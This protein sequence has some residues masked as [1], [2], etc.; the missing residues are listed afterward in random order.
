MIAITVGPANHVVI[1]CSVAQSMK[2]VRLPMLLAQ[3][4][5]TELNIFM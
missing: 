3:E 2:M 1:D 4:V 5:F